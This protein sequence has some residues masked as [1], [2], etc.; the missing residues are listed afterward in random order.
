MNDL[1][2]HLQQ[3][4]LASLKVHA[5]LSKAGLFEHAI[6][7]DRGRV[8]KGG[9]GDEPKDFATALGAKGPLIYYSDPE[10]TGRPTADTFAVASLDLKDRIWWKQDLKAMAPEHFEALWQRVIAHLQ[11]R[12]AP[13]YTKDV[14]AGCDPEYAVP[15]RFIGEFATHALFA[16][17]QFRKTLP[18]FVFRSEQRWTMLNVPSF[19]CVPERDH[20]RTNKIVVTDFARRTVLVAGPADYSGII[21][22]TIF[23]AMNFLLPARKMLS[24]HCSANVG[25]AGDAAILFGLSGTGKTTLS[26]DPERF[27]IGDDETAWT[28][29]GLSN[30]EDGCYAKLVDLNKSVEPVI[31]AALSMAGTVIENV[32]PLP[33]K[34]LAQTDPQELNLCDQSITENTRFSYGLECNPKVAAGSRGPHPKTIVLLTADAFGVLPPVSILNE[35]EV[36]YHF[37]MGFT[38]RLAG[39]EVGVT[40]P[41]AVFSACF[42][43]P[44]MPHPPSVYAKLLGEYMRAHKSRCILLN[45]GWTG[46]PYGVG[47]RMS[48]PLTRAM[49][50]AALRGDLD[51]VATKRHPTFNL[52]MP[53]T[54]PGVPDHILDPEQAWSDKAAYRAAA[55]DLHNLFRAHFDQQK[56]QS[57][58]IEPEM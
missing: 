31:A 44:F 21:K 29:A 51:Q 32:P 33:G 40:N 28:A 57:L 37:V 41:E 16:H 43:A 7:K 42:G 39:T 27:L 19:V 35:S 13:L 9:P 8:K 38:A 46:G 55:L 53:T 11:T 25:A 18:G 45:T 47:K 58:G 34:P 22:K 2:Q 20:T 26:A 50:N 30:L 52:L 1:A 10:C 5:N 36:M 6:A 48:L 49:L 12:Q 15:Y 56:F 3:L 4:G 17:I 23:T 14:I 24:M 54:C